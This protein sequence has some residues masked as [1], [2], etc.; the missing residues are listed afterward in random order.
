MFVQLRAEHAVVAVGL[1]PRTDLAATSGLELHE[2]MGGFLVNAELEARSN[3][4][5]VSV[6]FGRLC[7]EPPA[8]FLSL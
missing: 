1:E 2:E 4:W 7:I 5:V 6:A 8:R 3:L